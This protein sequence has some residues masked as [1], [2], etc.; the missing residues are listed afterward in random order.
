MTFAALISSFFFGDFIYV[1]VW[2]KK[3]QYYKK[4]DAIPYK[5]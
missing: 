5:V 1:N 3:Q 4:Y 2:E